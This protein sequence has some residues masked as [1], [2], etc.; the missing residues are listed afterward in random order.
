[1]TGIWWRFEDWIGGKPKRARSFEASSHAIIK[2]LQPSK[3]AP[4]YRCQSTSHVAV[5]QHCGSSER[6][7]VASSLSPDVVP[8]NDPR[9]CQVNIR[10]KPP[11][12]LLYPDVN[13]R[14]PHSPDLPL[15]RYCPTFQPPKGAQHPRWHTDPG[16]NSDTIC[17]SSVLPL[18][19]YCPLCGFHAPPHGFVFDKS[20]DDSR[21]DSQ[22]PP[23]P[24]VKTRLIRERYLHPYKECFVP[25]SNRCGTYRPCRCGDV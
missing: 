9:R 4:P 25:L 17:N 15:T 3:P 23:H 24:L 20:R 11:Y 13:V 18:A 2:E 12:P 21:D 14:G 8:L 22:S 19:R 16:S 6:S 7:L 10:G 5:S 1:M